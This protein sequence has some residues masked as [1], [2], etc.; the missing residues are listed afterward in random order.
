M[1]PRK[2]RLRLAASVLAGLL[3]AGSPRADLDAEI[4]VILAKANLAL[5]GRQYTQALAQFRDAIR[6]HSE[7]RTRQAALVGI[8]TCQQKLGRLDEAIGSFKE[9]VALGCAG[10]GPHEYSTVYQL[11]AQEQLAL[12]L[13]EKKDYAAALEAFQASSK[14]PSPFRVGCGL[15][16]MQASYTDN[17]RQ[18]IC[19]EGL[20]RYAEA[21][22]AYLRA[23]DTEFKPN[24]AARIAALYHAA[25]QRK[26]VEEI[27]RAHDARCAAEM[28]AH[29]RQ[30]GSPSQSG[31]SECA[32]SRAIRDI[33]E[34]YDQG[35]R[36]DVQA[37][38]DRIV[39]TER[40]TT[41]RQGAACNFI[42]ASDALARNR[43]KS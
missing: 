30:S 24:P 1:S 6:Q 5:D 21:V 8:G 26:D 33:L 25:G 28:S 13:L 40:G 41:A 2:Q 38:I 14:L 27:L 22:A 19:L 11:Q 16:L 12:A 36:G 20:G 42:E 10:C 34:I 29:R 15:G 32:S 43:R 31:D 39:C 3:A 18:G 35:E 7:D 4:G 37:L 17:V 9:A 23:A